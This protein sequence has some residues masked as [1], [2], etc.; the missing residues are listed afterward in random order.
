VDLFQKMAEGH[1]D[2]QVFEL[3]RYGFPLDVGPDFV[4]ANDVIN[5]SSAEKFPDQIAKYIKDELDYEALK[6]ANTSNFNFLHKSPLMSRPKDGD[7]CRV[8][9]DLSWPKKPGAL[10][11]ACVPENRYLNTEFALRL[12]TIDTICS[13]I[14][15]FEVPIM[16][17]KVDLARAFRQI[18]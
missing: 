12:P 10:V 9:L 3:L 1:S 14:N 6:I 7:K 18:R 16:L 15:A 11:N 17:Y 4:P 13:I 8:I 5:H 2:T